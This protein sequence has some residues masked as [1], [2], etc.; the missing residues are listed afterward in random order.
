MVVCVV[1]VF[2]NVLLECLS[3][4]PLEGG[5]F[6]VV[7]GV[8]ST[9]V[10]ASSVAARLAIAGLTVPGAPSTD[11]L[12]FTVVVSY[13]FTCAA[14]VYVFVDILSDYVF[15]VVY[16]YVLVYEFVFVFCCCLK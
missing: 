2:V 15:C 9:T 4:D 13:L 12:L 6:S 7:S 8:I 3:A 14:Y 1:V 16:G 5:A 11:L 10:D